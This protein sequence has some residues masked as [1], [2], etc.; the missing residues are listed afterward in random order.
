MWDNMKRSNLCIIGIEEG[1]ESQNTGIG[2]EFLNQTVA[3]QEI[4]ST[5]DKWDLIKLK[6]FWGLEGWLSG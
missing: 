1:E 3:V 4:R 2:K 5:I 6:S